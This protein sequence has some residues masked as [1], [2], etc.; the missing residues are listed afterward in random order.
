[1]PNIVPFQLNSLDFGF[2]HFGN[3]IPASF[4]QSPRNRRN[5]HC[6]Y[7]FSA[8]ISNRHTDSQGAG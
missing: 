3:L 8:V 2:E 7:R 1:M 6:G 5:S 4:G